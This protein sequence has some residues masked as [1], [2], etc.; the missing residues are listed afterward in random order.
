MKKILLLIFVLVGGCLNAQEIITDD[1]GRKVQLTLPVER[2]VCLSPA[3]VEMLYAIG[4]QKTLVAVSK[5]CDYPVA[6]TKLQKTGDFLNPDVEL[7]VK[8]NP[9]LVISGGGIQKKIIYKLEKL[10]IP[11][12]VLYP[13]NLNGISDNIKLLGKLTGREK[14]A[15][16][17]AEK[18]QK[19]INA[20][21]V[22][23]EKQKV[24]VYAE[25]WNSPAMAI[26]GASF[27]NELVARAG[28]INIFSDALSEYPKASKEE[29]IN[30][31][32]QVILFFYEPEKGYETRAWIKLTSAGKNK[33]TYIISKA[34]QDIIL[35][36]GPRS[37]Q[38]IR[39]L[40]KY[41]Q[42]EK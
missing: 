36:P 1:V 18:V 5:Y 16:K 41:I 33:R 17:I 38:G 7:I 27:V 39:I 23:N 9:S 3:H 42:D 14:E 22:K 35:R 2:I 29:I 21:G 34:E 8:L 11:V 10:K 6:A 30:R 19:K 24:R 40:K 32:P 37:E 28:G 26:G 15:E 13:K 12:V 4:A 20:A 25:L 31:D